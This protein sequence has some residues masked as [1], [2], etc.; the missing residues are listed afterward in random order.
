M[1]AEKDLLLN[2]LGTDQF[3]VRSDRLHYATGEMLGADDFQSEQLYHRRQLAMALRFLY[4]S[5]TL[6]GLKVVV[7]PGEKDPAD[8]AR[9]SEVQL[10]VKPGLA[11]DRV[12]R[13][14]EVPVP[15][16]LRLKRW[17]LYITDPRQTGDVRAVDRLAAAYDASGRTVAADVFLSFHPCE[18]GW[19]P[20]FASGPFDALDAS[21]PSRIRDAYELQLVLRKV[22]ASPTFDPW[23]AVPGTPTQAQL[24]EAIFAAWDT[25]APPSDEPGDFHEVPEELDDPTAIRLARIGV[26]VISAGAPERVDDLDWTAVSWNW[27]ASPAGDNV[28]NVDNTVRNFIVP[29]ALL[30]RLHTL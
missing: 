30:R 12:G 15:V 29:P 28:Q 6:A 8:P 14:V 22:G 18:R 9:L 25:L 21:Q 17:F 20:A 23:V 3:A 5:G 4:G 1:A 16:S 13:L 27:Q 19:T 26:P 24:Q 2:T 10:Q 7:V 11:I